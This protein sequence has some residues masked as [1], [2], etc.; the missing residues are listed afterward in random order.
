MPTESRPTKAMT[1]LE[2]VV[3]TAFLCFVFLPLSALAFGVCYAALSLIGWETGAAYVG[4]LAATAMG[5]YV[6]IW[7]CFLILA[8]IVGNIYEAFFGPTHE[9]LLKATPTATHQAP[10]EA[11]DS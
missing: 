2:N 5:L 6:L 8:P 7:I 11:P 4:D 9:A 3:M 1:P 10:G